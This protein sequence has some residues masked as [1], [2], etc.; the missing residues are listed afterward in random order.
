MYVLGHVCMIHRCL[1]LSQLAVLITAFCFS[2][3]QNGSKLKL[4]LQNVPFESRMA[5]CSHINVLLQSVVSFFC[6]PV[7]VSPL[8]PQ[9]PSWRGLWRSC[10]VDKVSTCSCRQMEPLMEQRKRTMVTVSFSLI[11]C[12]LHF[13]YHTYTA[14]LYCWSVGTLNRST[15]NSVY[16]LY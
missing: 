10:T 16:D 2:N 8:L 13:F 15:V 5:L 9:S 6:L 1:S 3:F 7:S 12:S 14:M 4:K 11:F